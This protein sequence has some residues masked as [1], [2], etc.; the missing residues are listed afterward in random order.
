MKRK[1]KYWSE[2]YGSETKLKEKF[3][4]QKEAKKLMQNFC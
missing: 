2:K 4:K 3:R 1:E